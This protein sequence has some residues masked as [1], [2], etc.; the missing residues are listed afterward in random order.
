MRLLAGL[1]G[2]AAALTL[3]GCQGAEQETAQAEAPAPE[4]AIEVPAED[5]AEAMAGEEAEA[6]A[7]EAPMDDD[8]DPTGNPI[9]PGRTSE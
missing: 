8:L 5:T 6:S 9:G 7:I 3:A 2:G 4:A 1:L